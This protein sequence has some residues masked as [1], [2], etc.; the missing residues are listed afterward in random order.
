MGP[1]CDL[2]EDWHGCFG[3]SG[4]FASFGMSQTGR[5]DRSPRAP[6]REPL[7]GG[8]AR[9]ATGRA[10]SGGRRGLPNRLQK[11]DKGAFFVTYCDAVWVS[12]C[13]LR[14]HGYL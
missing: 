1:V 9:V 11:A 2:G 13:L 4:G 5:R 10:G 8:W 3:G 14:P 6:C 7:A 12:T